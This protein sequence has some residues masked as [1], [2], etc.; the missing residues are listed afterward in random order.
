M[1]IELYRLA[2]LRLDELIQAMGR[3]NFQSSLKEHKR[4]MKIVEGS[5][6]P[7]VEDDYQCSQDGEKKKFELFSDY[8][9]IETLF[10]E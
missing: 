10:Y 9:C 6:V 7:L 8:S 3:L 4:L 1:E 2:N 5:C